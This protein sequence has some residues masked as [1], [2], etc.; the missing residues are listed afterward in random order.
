MGMFRTVFGELACANCGAGFRDGVQFKTG[1]DDALQE[2]EDGQQVAS[3]D[4]AP[5]AWRGIAERYCTT[6]RDV[7]IVAGIHAGAAVVEQ[8][9]SDAEL[10]LR[11]AATGES[12]A[13]HD[14]TRLIEPIV[15][16]M[17]SDAAPLVREPIALTT[18]S[19]ASLE[20]HFRG[21]RL[22]ANANDAASFKAYLQDRANALLTG[23]GWSDDE[24]REDLAVVVDD[25]RAIRIQVLSSDTA[26]YSDRG[27]LM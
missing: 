26:L 9:I 27:A 14:V 11:D 13:P 12:L 16:R 8:L 4:L 18:T 22:G 3:P 5:G 6:C 10:E 2:Y 1:D 7:W 20:V 17:F 24:L 15:A 23:L 19:V 25:T 21:V